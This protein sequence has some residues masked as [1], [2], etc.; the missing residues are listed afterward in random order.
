MIKAKQSTAW[1]NPGNP[2]EKGTLALIASATKVKPLEGGQVLAT[3]NVNLPADQA[4]QRHP[5]IIVERIRQ[6]PGRL[7]RGLGRQGDVL[8]PRRLHAADAR[9]RR[10]RWAAQT[11]SRSSK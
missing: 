4:S 3:Y 8:L 2:P 6:G 9:Q 7:F 1:L 5:A 11:S 10:R